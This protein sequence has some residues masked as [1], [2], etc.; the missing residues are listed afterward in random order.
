MFNFMQLSSEKDKENV[1][2]RKVSDALRQS[3]AEG[4][5]AYLQQ[6]EL[7]KLVR[8]SSTLNI[9]F[10]PKVHTCT[11]LFVGSSSVNNDLDDLHHLLLRPNLL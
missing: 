6:E 7:Q 9:S 3:E 5:E 2:V 11:N 8:L 1:K 10:P 4:Q